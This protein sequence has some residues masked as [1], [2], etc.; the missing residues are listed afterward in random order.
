MALLAEHFPLSAQMYFYSSLDYSLPPQDDPSVCINQTSFSSGFYLVSLMG[1]RQDTG[2]RE[3]AKVWEC[4]RLF[5]LVEPEL[6]GAVF[7]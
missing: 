6:A 3:E 7:F 5:C 4:I 2:W 1:G